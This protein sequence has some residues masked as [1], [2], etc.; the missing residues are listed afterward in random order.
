MAL[1][2]EIIDLTS[3]VNSPSQGR[4]SEVSFFYT[5]L[6]KTTRVINIQI[7]LILI[8]SVCYFI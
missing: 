2:M 5:S 3:P 4:P 7:V 1:P 8:Y 6:V